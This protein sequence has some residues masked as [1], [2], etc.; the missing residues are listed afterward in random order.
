MPFCLYVLTNS[1]TLVCFIQLQKLHAKIS[2]CSSQMA[3]RKSQSAQLQALM[4]QKNSGRIPGIVG[5]LGDLG[6]I[7]CAGLELKTL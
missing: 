2:E 4:D 6:K 7:S 3:S 5:R 1:S